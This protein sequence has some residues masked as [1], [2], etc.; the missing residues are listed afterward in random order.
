[1]GRTM[2]SLTQFAGLGLTTL[3]LSACAKNGAETPKPGAPAPTAAQSAQGLRLPP[4]TVIATW[5]GGK[6]TYGE[7]HEKRATKFA[8]LH[9][10]YL[11][12]LFRTEQQELEQYMLETLVE[13]KAKAEGKTGEQY[14]EA[15]AARAEVPEAELRK[16]YED[17]VGKSPQAPPFEAIQDRIK[18]YLAMQRTVDAVKSEAKLEL[19]LPAPSSAA[20]NFDLTGRP[21]K[22]PKD[23]Q[24]TVVE[25]SDFQC[26]YCA[27]A[28]PAVEA[29][30]KAYPKD[31]KV[32]FMHFPLNFHPEAVPAAVASQC[33]NLQG[34]FWEMHDKIFENQ[35]NM[36]KAQYSAYAKDLGLDLGKFEACSSDPATQEWVMKD[37]AQG[38]AAGVEGTPSFFINGI[39]HQGLPT[40]EVVAPFIKKKS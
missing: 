18:T 7:L 26:P 4:E 15:L 20:A 33:A 5:Q 14:L 13:D 25:F 24:I 12:D 8:K 11:Q 1:M 28:T 6:L 38:E 40:P 19:D 30:L 39:Q 35:G 27:R 32:Y 3:L 31:V 36:S 34:K 29:L 37:M 9:N 21:V 22:G 16:F 10:R 2:R 23:A 17:Q